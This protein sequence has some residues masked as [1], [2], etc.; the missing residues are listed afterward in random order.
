MHIRIIA[1][2]RIPSK[3]YF[4]PHQ[5]LFIPKNHKQYHVKKNKKRLKRMKN[6][7]LKVSCKTSQRKKAHK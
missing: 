4:I 7:M 5:T 1:I 3:I 6:E 2:L